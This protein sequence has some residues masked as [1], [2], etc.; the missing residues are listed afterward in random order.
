MVSPLGP[1]PAV[2]EELIK[3]SS[4]TGDRPNQQAVAPYR[5]GVRHTPNPENLT[6]WA[7]EHSY[8]PKL[9]PAA[10]RHLH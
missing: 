10:A 8:Q 7:L 6:R 1:I 3:S 2:D 5:C 9:I 4:A